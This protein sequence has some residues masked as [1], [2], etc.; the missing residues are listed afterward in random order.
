MNATREL[1]TQYNEKASRHVAK[2]TA[3]DRSE[4]HNVRLA[5]LAFR[6]PSL[7]PRRGVS[8][9]PSPEDLL[10][11]GCLGRARIGNTEAFAVHQENGKVNGIIGC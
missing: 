4:V 6:L 2:I 5:Y 3:E 10:I 9:L 11:V 1:L 8:L 7:W